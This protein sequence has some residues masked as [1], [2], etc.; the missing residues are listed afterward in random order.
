MAVI[1][2]HRTALVSEYLEANILG[3]LKT[4]LESVTFSERCV[5]SEGVMTV[6]MMVKVG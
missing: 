6:G 2:G 1:D 4:A 5:R 3:H